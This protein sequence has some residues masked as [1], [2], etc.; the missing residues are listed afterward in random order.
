MNNGISASCWYCGRLLLD[1]NHRWVK[2]ENYAI[3]KGETGSL[4][5]DC[6]KDS[7]NRAYGVG[8]VRL[9]DYIQ[10]GQTDPRELYYHL[11]WCQMGV[12]YYSIFAQLDG[13]MREIR[14]M[15]NGGIF[16]SVYATEKTNKIVRYASEWYIR[17]NHAIKKAQD[18]RLDNCRNNC[19]NNLGTKSNMEDKA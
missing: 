18:Y 11:A 3:T 10:S 2:Y 6:E 17:Y 7:P 5:L 19:T 1:E 14:Q 9:V 15:A 13:L 16:S 4:C 12:E 8:L